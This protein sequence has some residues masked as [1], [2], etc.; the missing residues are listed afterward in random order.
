MGQKNRR[1]SRGR[2][3]QPILSP[4]SPETNPPKLLSVSI[5]NLKDNPSGVVVEET[6]ISTSFGQNLGEVLDKE[7][8]KE[9]ISTNKL[10]NKTKEVIMSEEVKKN[11]EVVETTNNA[12]TTK[13]APKKETA[14]AAPQKKAEEKKAEAAPAEATGA[15]PAKQEAPKKEETPIATGDTK[16]EA[17]QDLRKA[18]QEQKPETASREVVIREEYDT[19]RAMLHNFG[20]GVA[21]GGGI[22]LG[23]ALASGVV[24]LVK[25]QF[26]GGESDNNE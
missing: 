11:E 4:M 5:K 8:T 14:K 10:T 24:Y 26:G 1:D 20:V 9:D 19:G 2:F 18:L 15:A 3:A 7:L 12:T 6:E 25:R 23:A 16:G 22:V 13:A 21:I 17:K